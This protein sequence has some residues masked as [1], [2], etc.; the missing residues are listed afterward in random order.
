M[1]REAAIRRRG[2]L[3]S[4]TVSARAAIT[5]RDVTGRSVK[6]G[7]HLCEKHKHKYQFISCKAY[8]K[9]RVGTGVK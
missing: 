2:H 7:S 6:P 8:K 9:N 4:F 1:W 3:Y 5:P